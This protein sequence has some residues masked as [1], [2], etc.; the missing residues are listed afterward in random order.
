MSL[1]SFIMPDIFQKYSDQLKK[2][3]SRAKVNYASQLEA[4]QTIEGWMDTI[5][6]HVTLS[7]RMYGL[8]NFLD[9][10]VWV[11][12]YVSIT[13]QKL[14]ESST[15]YQEQV[16]QAKQIMQPF[17]LRRLKSEVEWILSTQLCLWLNLLRCDDKHC[18]HRCWISYHQN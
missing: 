8:A 5:F 4:L 3:F 15:Y 17:I 18:F 1:L 11:S 2:T 9:H 13:L 14:V 12:W 6:L 7:I 16:G 10:S